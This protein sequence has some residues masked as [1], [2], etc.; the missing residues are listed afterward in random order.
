MSGLLPRET[1][2][3]QPALPILGQLDVCGTD[4]IQVQ[5]HTGLIND[6]PAFPIAAEKGDQVV[7]VAAV[8]AVRF[9]G[10]AIKAFVCKLTKD[11]NVEF[12]VKSSE[13]TV[14]QFRVKKIQSS[15]TDR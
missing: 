15:S 9:C 8:H 13:H 14:R 12:T 6:V 2:G 7:A 3:Q 1:V 10:I 5:R 4:R 11:T